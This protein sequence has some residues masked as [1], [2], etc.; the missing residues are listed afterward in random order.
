MF[1]NHVSLIVFFYIYLQTL[2]QLEDDRISYFKNTLSNFTNFLSGIMPK[3]D[4]V[5][6]FL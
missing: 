1:F 4:E 5:C 3:V 6:P 2:E